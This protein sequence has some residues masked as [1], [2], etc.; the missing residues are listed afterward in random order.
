MDIIEERKISYN[1]NIIREATGTICGVEHTLR[2]RKEGRKF[3]VALT[4]KKI[5]ITSQI[6]WSKRRAEGYF[7]RLVSTHDFSE[8][9]NNDMQTQIPNTQNISK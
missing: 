2:L 7:K 6:F 5:R 9:V 4:T 8:R 3:I 1:D